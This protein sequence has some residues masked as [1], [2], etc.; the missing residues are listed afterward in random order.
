[1][2]WV[3][4]CAGWVHVLGGC[5]WMHVLGGCM[6]MHV[7]GGC[8]CWVGACAWWVHVDACAGWVHVD[9]CAGWVHV[10][11]CAGWVHVLGGC[12]CLVGACAGWVHVLGGCMCWVGACAG[13]GW[14]W[15]GLR[16]VACAG[17]LISPSGVGAGTGWHVLGGTALGGMCW[18]LDKSFRSG[19]CWY[20]VACAGWGW[21]WVACGAGAG[22]DC[23]GWHVLGEYWSLVSPEW[24]LVLGGCCVCV[25]CVSSN[26]V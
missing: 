25:N 17:S 20:W 8:M 16:W 21:Y 1:M 24:V 5:M 19:C 23:A 4:A 12:M 18:V 3:G 26:A 9:A 2:C 15:V 22:W 7:L 11:A 14:C 10:D 13:W 6:W